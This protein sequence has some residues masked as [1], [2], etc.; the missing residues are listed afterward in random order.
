MALRTDYKDDILDLA[1]NTKRKYRMVTN[2]DGT[3]S[4]ED[5]TVYSQIGD[6]FGAAEL[7]EIA[8][9]VNEGG[10]NMYYDPATDIKYLRNQ[11][12]EWVAVGEGGLLKN[13]LYPNDQNQFVPYLGALK[14]ITYQAGSTLPVITYGDTMSITYT[15]SG[16]CWTACVITDLIDVTGYKK[17]VLKHNSTSTGSSTYESATLF[18]SETK[19]ASMTPLACQNIISASTNKAGV[20]ELELAGISGEMYIGIAF[21]VN[22]KSITVN[23]EEMYLE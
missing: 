19:E 3:V 21:Q 7:N 23:V 8:N 20:V 10:S 2:A 13:Y 11:N 14:D 15:L 16:G 22:S 5:M 4:F 1:Q 18:I 12:G 9:S 6:S 17:L